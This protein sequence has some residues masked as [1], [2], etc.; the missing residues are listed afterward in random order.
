MSEKENRVALTQSQLSLWT[1]QQLSPTFPLYNMAH[2]FEL[3]GAIDTDSFKKAFDKLI[4]KVDILRTVFLEELGKPYQT[5]LETYNYQLKVLDFSFKT[6][7]DIRACLIKRSQEIFDLSIPPFDSVLIK[8]TPEKYLWYL[9]VHHILTDATTTTLLHNYLSVYYAELVVANS[10]TL[11]EIP[12]FYDYLDFEKKAIKNDLADTQKKYWK[13][14]LKTLKN[15]INLYGER[16]DGT[17]TASRRISFKLGLERSQVIRELAGSRGIRQWTLD[18]TLFNLF[19]TTLFVYLYKI[20][21][22]KELAIGAPI[23][24][25][26]SEKFKK[27]P[28]LFIEVFPILS[29][30]QDSDTFLAVFNKVKIETSE[31]LRNAQPGMTNLDVSRNISI[32]LNYIK[33]SFSDFAGIASKSEWLHSGYSDPRHSLRCT[34]NDMDGSGEFELLF[35]LNEGVFDEDMVQSVPNH[36]LIVL[37]GLLNNIETSIDDISLADKIE[38]E[39]ITKDNQDSFIS[40]VDQFQSQ[41]VKTPES[42]AIVHNSKEYS[43][44]VINDRANQLAHYLISKNINKEDK[45]CIYLDRSLTYIIAVLA[46][47]KVGATFVPIASNQAKKR[48]NYILKDS[49]G[50][51]VLTSKA[52]KNNIDT[53]QIETFCLDVNNDVLEKQENK[54]IEVLVEPLEV[55]YL[56]YTS[57]STGKPKGVLITQEGITNYLSSAD[58]MY[59]MDS[60]YI[61]PLFTSIGFDLTITSTFLP[62][63]YGGKMII[64]KE[65]KHGPDLSLFDVIEENKVNIIKLTPSH[66]SLLKDKNLK[67]SKI[68]S[69]IVGG[70]EFKLNLANTIKD[71]FSSSLKIFNEYGP[72]EA[73][74]GCVVS[75][76]NQLKH[77]NKSVPIG[78]PIAGIQIFILDKNKNKV[79]RGV[80][81]ELYIAGKGLAKGYINNKVE[82]SQKFGS[83]SF[84]DIEKVYQT[85]DLVRENK[86][87]ELEYLGRIDEQVKFR[88]F[89]IE[90]LDIEINLLNFPRIKNVAV[91]LVTK[92]ATDNEMQLVA[93]YTGESIINSEELSEYLVTE[94]PDYMIP[95]HYQYLEQLPLTKNGKVDKQELKNLKISKLNE[96]IFIEPQGEIEE[97]IAAIWQEVLK[98]E[99]V[100][101]K[102]HFISLGGNSLAALRITARINEEVEIKFPLNKVFE[103]PTIHQYAKYIEETLIKLLNE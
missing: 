72:T 39:N 18:L 24:N 30:L 14:K 57:G 17:N 71:S 34:V 99:K 82:T 9:N 54:N 13:S 81:G 6:K 41:V 91:Q 102:D 83:L 35:D 78:L 89:R 51:V 85:G 63:L 19:L 31:Y 27:T 101:S 97:L 77:K 38:L 53:N 56:L 43:Y 88:G 22:R 42:I 95:T 80:P 45:V 103:L 98:L 62:L 94:L 79:T 15:S 74:V 73:T 37:D 20:S 28:G 58:Q 1:G 61:F 7:E 23:H 66:L 36:F 2:S 46:T 5:V 84:L 93:F 26:V 68:K 100:G 48:I 64:Y 50:K 60:S 87:G 76:F 65:P 8:V 11:E 12:Q 92:F 33:A 52:L 4:Q 47:L 86:D 40:I 69:M 70:E 75:K 32:V 90:L 67:D 3:N 59:Q 29:Q 10:N 49:Q 96:N 16:N 21:G 44:R 25:R 55:C